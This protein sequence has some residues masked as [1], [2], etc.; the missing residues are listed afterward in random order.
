MFPEGKRAGG[1]GCRQEGREEGIEGLPDLIPSSCEAAGRRGEMNPRSEDICGDSLS[2]SQGIVEYEAGGGADFWNK[3]YGALNTRKGNC[4]TKKQNS[5]LTL[6]RLPSH[7][8][9]S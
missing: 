9:T 7:W 1:K 2:G 5:A 8:K 6:K 4:G 3:I